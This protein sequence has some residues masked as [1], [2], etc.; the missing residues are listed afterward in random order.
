VKEKLREGN[1]EMGET[2]NTNSLFDNWFGEKSGFIYPDFSP[3]QKIF[4]AKSVSR[5]MD[6]RGKTIRELVEI[7][8]DNFN[9]ELSLLIATTEITRLYAN[10]VINKGE[11]LK[12]HHPEVLVVKRWFTNNDT[13]FDNNGV[14]HG[15]CELCEKFDNTVVPIDKNWPNGIFQPPSHLGCRC[16]ITATTRISGKISKDEKP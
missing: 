2:Q 10:K 14:R 8:G 1:F 3:E 16:W 12:N 11:R 4:I 7:L 5:Y 9:D 13:W 15:V 6:I